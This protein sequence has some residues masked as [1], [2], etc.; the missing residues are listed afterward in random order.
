MEKHWSQKAEENRELAREKMEEFAKSYQENPETIVEYL[1]FSKNFYQY[2]AGNTALIYQQNPHAT[3]VKSFAGWKKE[4]VSVNRGEKGIAIWCPVQS[5]LLKREDGSMVPLRKATKEEKDLYKKGEMEGVVKQ[6]FQIGYVFDIA[7]TNF[8]K[9][10]YPKY[11]HMGQVSEDVEKIITALENYTENELQCSVRTE[12]LSSITLRGYYYKNGIV[13]N[14]KLEGVEKLSTLSH[15]MGHAI[16]KHGT[17][18][19]E[20]GEGQREYE[21]DCI[22]VM[23][24]DY[25]GIEITDARRRHFKH[26]YNQFEKEMQEK[27]RELPPEAQK[28]EIEKNM[29]NSFE[30]IHRVMGKHLNQI[31]EYIKNPEVVQQ[32]NVQNISAEHRVVGIEKNMRAGKG[33]EM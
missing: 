14:E 29:N 22:S 7:Q 13:L 19:K 1:K 2:S 24:Q 25:L 17:E 6:G 28:R 10:Q 3:F 12:D 11:F 33:L 21:A 9:E 31:D 5:T 27:Y 16:E 8:P 15:E 20:K 4:G 23:L 18:R 30:Y 26:A 32:K